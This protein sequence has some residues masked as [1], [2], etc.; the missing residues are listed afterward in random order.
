MHIVVIRMPYSVPPCDKNRLTNNRE[1]NR[2]IRQTSQSDIMGNAKSKRNRKEKTTAKPEESEELTQQQI[3]AVQ[4]TWKAVKQDLQGHGI[5]FFV[6]IFDIAPGAQQIFAKF[7]DLPKDELPSN[8]DVQKHALNVMETVGSAVDGLDDLEAL[9]PVLLDLGAKHVQWDVQ[10][11]H[12][13]IVGQALLETLAEGLGEA[14]TPTVKQAWTTVYNCVA[15]GMK[16]G[17]RNEREQ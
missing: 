4:L 17:M 13:D 6:R 8:P 1:A 14:F 12:F 5:K 10:E 2:T 9:T 11:E 7:R 3:E 15:H 16:Q